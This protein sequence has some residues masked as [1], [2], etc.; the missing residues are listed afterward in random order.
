MSAWL[1]ILAIV[2]GTLLARSLLPLLG[3]R[4]QL[5]PAV[6]SALR[7]APGCA[8]AAI[9]IPELALRQGVLTLGAH[10]LQL[11][12]AAAAALVSHYTRS[13]LGTIVGGMAMY[14]VL[15]ALFG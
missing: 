13:T 9:V 10:N 2:I 5:T 3:S 4:V 12:A 6:E 8:L 14:W 7:Y 15:L 11:P 1:G